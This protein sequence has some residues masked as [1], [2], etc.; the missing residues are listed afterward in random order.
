MYRVK[1]CTLKNGGPFPAWLCTNMHVVLWLSEY[2]NQ[3]CL[4]L[5]HPFRITSPNEHIQDF[6]IVSGEK[7][8]LVLMCSCWWVVLEHWDVHYGWKP[9]TKRKQKKSGLYCA[10]VQDGLHHAGRRSNWQEVWSSWSSWVKTNNC[11]WICQ[12]WTVPGSFEQSQG[13]NQTPLTLSHQ[14]PSSSTLLFIV[15]R[16]GNVIYSMTAI[17]DMLSAMP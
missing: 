10:V 3:K 17:A 12:N 15:N 4:K 9:L 1:S 8:Y 16:L 6:P 13:M 2:L 14:L 7:K 5:T 11:S